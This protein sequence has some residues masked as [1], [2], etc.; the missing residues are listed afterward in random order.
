MQFCCFRRVPWL[1]SWVDDRQKVAGHRVARSEPPRAPSKCGTGGWNCRA[2]HSSQ[3]QCQHEKVTWH[4]WTFNS[5]ADKYTTSLLTFLPLTSPGRLKSPPP[6]RPSP[7][8]FRPTLRPPSPHQR[9]HATLEPV[10]CPCP[11]LRGCR[12]PSGQS[13][14]RCS[15]LKCI[16]SSQIIQ[17]QD[18]DALL[19]REPSV[20]TLSLLPRVIQSLILGLPCSLQMQTGNE[21]TRWYLAG[22]ETHRAGEGLA[23]V[24]WREAGLLP[25]PPLFSLLS[26]LV[27]LP[28]LVPS[29]LVTHCW[30]PHSHPLLSEPFIISFLSPPCP[31]QPPKRLIILGDFFIRVQCTDTMGLN[32]DQWIQEK[33]SAFVGCRIFIYFFSYVF[34]L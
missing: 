18:A 9:H 19:N 32:A 14:I 1:F 7:S 29:F 10:V 27:S 12:T 20:S 23:F 4:P 15:P 30:L 2:R 26:S 16:S 8:V 22:S 11:R 28:A 25:C 34:S 5:A 33:R 31:T 13:S 21:T 3:E 6:S 24:A 17:P